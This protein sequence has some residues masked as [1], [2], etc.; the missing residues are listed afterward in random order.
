MKKYYLILGIIA[1]TLMACQNDVEY[2]KETNNKNE[3]EFPENEK[4]DSL[5]MNSNFS[6]ILVTSSETSAVLSANLPTIADIAIDEDARVLLLYKEAESLTNGFTQVDECELNDNHVQFTLTDLKPET[7]Y[8]ALLQ[9]ERQYG[10]DITSDYFGFKTSNYYSEEGKGLNVRINRDKGLVASV[11]IS[12]IGY[13][14]DSVDVTLNNLRFEY[15]MHNNANYTKWTSREFNADEL[16]DGEVEFDIP[17]ES[18]DYLAERATYEYVAVMTPEDDNYPAYTIGKDNEFFRFQMGYAEITANISTPQITLNNSIIEVEVES[19]DVFYD[20]VSTDDYKFGCPTYA[21][22]Y[23][24]KG[25]EEWTLQTVYRIDG[26]L[27]GSF[28]VNITEPNT[29]YEVIAVVEAG[30][31]QTLCYS[32]IVEISVPPTE[33]SSAKSTLTKQDDN[34]LYIDWNT[35][36]EFDFETINPKTGEVKIE[37]KDSETGDTKLTIGNI[38]YV[39]NPK[40]MNINSI[41]Q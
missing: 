23:R 18:D 36:V 26:A 25:S 6:K 38:I 35:D 39:A 19:V 17:G 37:V 8:L 33:S 30:A 2:Q 13:V 24:V 3:I 5:A 29:V 4:A 32:E 20:G 21:I 41:A 14:Q 11:R 9:L 22:G 12:D 31:S 34:V 7:R 10:M 15:R 16:S 28:A 27:S 1:I 40:E